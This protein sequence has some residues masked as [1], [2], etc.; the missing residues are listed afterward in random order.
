MNRFHQAVTTLVV[1]TLAAL[2]GVAL[3]Q[4][5]AQAP[6]QQAPTLEL[7]LEEV[8]KRALEN[9]VDIAVE[10]FSPEAAS[11]SVRSAE[12]AFDFG[13]SAGLSQGKRSTPQSSV[14]SGAQKVDTDTSIWN[15]GASQ[16]LKTGGQLNLT[17]N[18]QRQDTNNI[19]ST[20]NPSY[21]STLTLNLTQPLLRNFKVDAARQQLRVSKK[22]KEISDVAFTQTV[23]NT[24]ANVK[25][26]YY[27]L[28]YAIDALDAARKSLALAQKLLEENQIR[29][30]VGTMAPLDVIEAESEVAAR[31][32]S[33][34]SAEANLLAAEDNLKR[35]IFPKTDG[36]MWALH[37][38][39][40]DR[41]SADPMPVDEAAAIQRALENRTDIVQA[42]LSLESSNYTV[43]YA[44]SLTKPGLDLVASYGMAGIGGTQIERDGL[45]GPIISEIPGGY[46][47]A[48]SS[49]FG[50][51][52][53]NW[54]VGVNFSL[55]IQNRTAKGN[56][57]RARIARDQ[58]LASL[59]RLEMTIATEVRS[60]ARA[61][62]TNFK[63]VDSTRAA[64]VLQ[65]RRLDAEEK[66]FA[67]GMSTNFLVTQAQRDLR[68]AQVA[69][70]RAIADYRESII[71]FERVQQAG[72]GGGGGGI[73]VDI[74]GGATRVLN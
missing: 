43:E 38:V 33:V 8:V 67:A 60:A 31:Q 46:G 45:G 42:R 29:V 74:G 54:S 19:F 44:K 63:Q 68:T 1:I 73:T 59:V 71:N 4:Q 13:T 64:R 12:G 37:L 48:L 3:A 41:P 15:V 14:F 53:P 17:F 16:L 61:V 9:N 49:V 55:P 25:Q 7:S 11:E 57:A 22:N 72:A 52:Y 10:R 62:E 65:E 47:D 50:F 40:T 69:E 51:D 6:A 20:F 56:Q 35:T 70:L 26:N 34:I 39:P 36:A 2:P 28:I 21:S 66:K 32:V 30:K 24:I 58:A 27:E 23:V 18:N 5:A